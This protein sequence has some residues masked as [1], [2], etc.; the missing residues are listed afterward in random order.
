[1]TKL[2]SKK[3]AGLAPSNPV[4]RKLNISNATRSERYEM[5]KQL[6]KK[7]PRSSHATFS[8]P[9]KRP[10]Q[11]EIMKESE[12]GR[13]EK[14]LPM[15]HG[16]MAASP[17]TFYRGSALNMAIDLAKTP[18]TGV[19]VQACGDAHL[20]NFGGFATPERNIIFSI[21]DLDETLPAP[22]EWD[23]KRLAAS[24]VVACQHN[25]IG[26]SDAKDAVQQCVRSYRKYMDEY[27]EMRIMELWHHSLGADM[28]L[29]KLD[30]PELRAKGE[31]RIEKEKGRSI[32]EEMFPQLAQGRGNITYI[33][34]QLP[35]IFHWEGH[36]PGEIHKIV[37]EAFELYRSSLSPVYSFLLNRYELKDGAI[38]VVGVGS[39]GTACWVFLL[40][41]G[42]G[43]PLFLQAKEARKSVLED[44][45]GKSIYANH[46]QRVINGYRI[47]QPFSDPFLGWTQGKLG[48]HYFFRQLRDIKI[49]IRVETFGK[50]EMINFADWC[51]QAL[52][53]SHAR[54][55]DAALLSG[56]MGK[57]DSFDQAIADFSFAYAEQNEKDYDALMKAI[58]SGKLEAEFDA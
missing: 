11:L 27:S 48:R 53:L 46:G 30:D 17:F 58:K 23:V 3:P 57:S 26:K 37:M 13:L 56:Y 38:K 32:A 31:K 1:M 15:R 45:A 20:C 16:R 35:A 6:R 39:V 12:K 40:M 24:F 41:T 22:W 50:A 51:G 14:L 21:N 55:G 8:P 19:Y 10:S 44:F 2:K 5:G 7:C 43:E 18:S 42:D 9:A 28:M 25:G 47:M 4:D 54:S 29:A 49:S 34:D 36:K 52:A 33:Q